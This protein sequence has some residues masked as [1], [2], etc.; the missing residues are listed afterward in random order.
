[1]FKIK[2]II[3][4]SIVGGSLFHNTSAYST[5]E[6]IEEKIGK[7]LV[8]TYKKST[9]KLD[10][11]EAHLE[12]I[13]TIDGS[14]NR[15]EYKKL[16]KKSSLKAAKCLEKKA[17][18]LVPLKTKYE[19]KTNMCFLSRYNV[20][21]DA[22]NLYYPYNKKKAQDLAG[23]F[24]S[25]LADYQTDGTMANDVMYSMMAS[26]PSPTVDFIGLYECMQRIC[27]EED[28]HEEHQEFS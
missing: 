9:P 21:V 3:F 27:N 23:I 2:S 6:D 10:K 8:G 5:R 26:S 4:S 25:E 11:L 17:E 19:Q 14:K 22:A 20:L 28:A 18:T 12:I 15:E 13:K 16:H 24:I 1:M 7:L